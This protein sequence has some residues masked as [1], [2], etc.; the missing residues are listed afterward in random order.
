MFEDPVNG[1]ELYR[2]NDL[3]ATWDKTHDSILENVC[4]SYGYYF[5]TLHASFE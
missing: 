5:G 2:S 4:Y 3:G 1:A